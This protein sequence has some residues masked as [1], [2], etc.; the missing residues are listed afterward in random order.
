M[1][2]N[3]PMKWG[4]PCVSP[5]PNH[6]KNKGDCPIANH[7]LEDLCLNFSLY[8][9]AKNAVRSTLLASCLTFVAPI[10]VFAETTLKVAQQQDPQNLDP[11]DTFRLSWG[12][13]ASNV[14]DGL[15]FRGEDLQLQPG[16]ATKW[17]LLDDETRIRFTLREGVEFH[18]GGTIQ[19][20][21]SQIHF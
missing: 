16:L 17:E 7:R 19:R 11:I 10:T 18:N 14:F 1:P 3:L 9:T 13:I 2:H 4:Q 6:R 5:S 8:L 20:G 21:C 15:V 12:S